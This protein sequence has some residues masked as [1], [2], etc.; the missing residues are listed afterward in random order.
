MNHQYFPGYSVKEFK[1]K[2]II[3]GKNIFFEIA[4]K[5]MP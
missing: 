2:D 4:I 5:P 1:T 3:K